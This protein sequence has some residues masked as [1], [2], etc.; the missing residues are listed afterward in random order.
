VSQLKELLDKC[1]REEL[2]PLAQ[3]RRIPD[4]KVGLKDLSL[5]ID[6]NLRRQGGHVVGNLVRAEGPPWRDILRDIAE[7][8]RLPSS[9]SVEELEAAIVRAQ[10]EKTWD[11]LPPYLRSRLWLQFGD[12][13]ELPP[14]E[15]A[16][17][18]LEV[19]N[20]L[21]PTKFTFKSAASMALKVAG[22][23]L[24]ALLARP[25]VPFFLIGGVIK[26]TGPKMAI[27]I[28]AALHIASLRLMVKHRITVGFVGSPSSGKDAA[29]KALF[30]VDTGNVSPIA[31]S[32][33]EVQVLEVQD[34]TALF[35]VNTPGMGD[36]VESVTEE[37]RQVM[38]HIDV[39]IYVLNAEGGVQRREL[40]DY[41]YCLKSG[42]P[43][44]VCLNKMDLIRPR[45]KDRYVEDARR[46]LHSPRVMTECAFDPHPRIFP[47]PLGVDEVQA[48][49]TQTLT[50]LGKDPSELPWMP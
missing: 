3:H 16:T 17:F 42:K 22:G 8:L 18:A 25:L 34:A 6:Q 31:G 38:A 37:A 36:V 27:L 30:G 45:D 24:G 20:K 14:E 48:W 50:W 21:G 19:H 47:E 2:E 29:I 46:K 10:L 40:M 35:L 11:E 43:T 41:G 33:K 44:M 1:T 13:T 15:G 4:E 26:M 32:T 12:P 28:P 23:G 7:E 9:G 49:L 39:F 5:A